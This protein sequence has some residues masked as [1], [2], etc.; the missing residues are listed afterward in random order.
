LYLAVDF[1]GI[2]RIGF[3]SQFIDPPRNFPKQFHRHG[4]LGQLERDVPPVTDP[5]VL[6]VGPP[7]LY[8]R[9]TAPVAPWPTAF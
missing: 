4:N 9:R 6:N 5:W 8:L 1:L 3:L 2:H 7:R